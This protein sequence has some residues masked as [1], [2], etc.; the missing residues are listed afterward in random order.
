M[1]Q[2][3]GVGEF[4][5]FA[6]EPPAAAVD[7][8]AA[9]AGAAAPAGPAA[10]SGGPAKKKTLLGWVYESLGIGYLVIFLALSV[11]LV[12]LFVMNMLAARRD[13]LVSSGTGGLVRREAQRKRLSGRL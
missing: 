12:S 5:E 9:D 7:Q 3:E 1:A 2:E 6:E 13:T 11:S 10:T 4:A 8:P